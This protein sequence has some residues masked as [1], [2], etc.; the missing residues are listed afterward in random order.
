MTAES[1]TRRKQT[2]L[3]LLVLALQVVSQNSGLLAPLAVDAVLSIADPATDNNADLNNIKVV[4][5]LGGTVDD[6]ELI[7]GLVF[8]QKI[9]KAAGGPTR[10]QNAKI[11]VLQFC[12]S[13]P[14]TD[15]SG[16]LHDKT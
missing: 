10:M 12:L 13:P 15:V 2:A 5:K 14:K 11:A 9:S 4:Q 1:C 8:S 6:T 16:P 3:L 7:Q